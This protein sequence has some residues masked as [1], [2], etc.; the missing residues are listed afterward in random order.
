MDTLLRVLNMKQSSL[1]PDFQTDH[2]NRLPAINALNEGL[3]PISITLV[4]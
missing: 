2:P 1:F 4:T 3:R